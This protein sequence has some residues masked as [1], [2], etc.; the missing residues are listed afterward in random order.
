MNE[1][2]KEISNT[3]NS[4]KLEDLLL[5]SDLMAGMARADGK[6][7]E[8]EKAVSQSFIESQ[9]GEKA[10]LVKRHYDYVLQEDE[11]DNRLGTVMSFMK[12]LDEEDKYK[13]LRC[14]SSVAVCDGE[15]DPRELEIIRKF[16][17]AMEI[18]PLK[19]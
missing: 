1:Q 6:V 8:V 19:A 11:T 15:L 4:T 12:K 7:L 16:A 9:Y 14:L 5:Q 18:D 3:E 10:S 17:E 2:A 13:L